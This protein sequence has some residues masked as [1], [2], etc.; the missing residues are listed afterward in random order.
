MNDLKRVKWAG[1]AWTIENYHRDLKQFCLIERAQV[2]ARKTWHNHV[3]C[4]LRAFLRLETYCYHNMIT[5]F[6]D[7]VSIIRSAVRQ[8]ISRPI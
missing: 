5:W 4:C 7:K 1:F 2:R 3:L 8:F 6:E